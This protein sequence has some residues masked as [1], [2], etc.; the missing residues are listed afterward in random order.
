MS[1]T[2]NIYDVEHGSCTHIITPNGK[3]FLVDIG[4][5]SNKSISQYLK[6]RYFKYQG[7]IDYLVIT[8]P[9]LDHI[10]DLENLYTYNIT[11]RVLSRNKEAFPL[12]IN[13][14]DS[15][16]EKSLKN[17]ANEMNDSYNTAVCSNDD[18]KEEAFNGGVWMY[19]FNPIIHDADKDDLNNYS[20]VVVMLE[21]K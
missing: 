6:N 1:L 3:H 20:C 13:S 17:K 2:V 14:Y 8:H 4:T 5:K 18:P 10:A 11:P 7:G 16:A 9:H 19:V 15:S 12:E 21:Y